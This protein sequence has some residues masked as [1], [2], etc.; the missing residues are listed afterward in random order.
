MDFYRFGKIADRTKTKET[1]NYVSHNFSGTCV[2]DTSDGGISFTCILLVF[3]F[4]RNG[5]HN[6]LEIQL[7]H[8]IDSSFSSIDI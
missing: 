7:Y 8:D 5:L 3:H 6:M 2:T 4:L 1:F